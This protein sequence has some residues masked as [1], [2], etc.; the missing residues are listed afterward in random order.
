MTSF[1]EDA[2]RRRPTSSSS[3]AVPSTNSSPLPALGCLLD[4]KSIK[5]HYR[6]HILTEYFQ[7][8]LLKK[9]LCVK[10]GKV[11]EEVIIKVQLP[12]YQ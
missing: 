4:G 8:L 3:A 10:C 5:L 2:L 7:K 1:P 9:M 6:T 11:H 12:G